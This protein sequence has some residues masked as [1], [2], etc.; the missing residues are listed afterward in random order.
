MERKEPLFHDETG[1]FMSAT[2]V[3]AR[4]PHILVADDDRGICRL[5]QEFL[6]S[7][8]ARITTVG[9]GIEAIKV[10]LDDPADLVITDYHMPRLD[11]VEVLRSV[12]GHPSRRPIPVLMV[13]ALHQSL[14]RELEV[15]RLAPDA[16]F[17]KPFDGAAVQAKARSLL[18]RS[19]S[20]RAAAARTP[21]VTQDDELPAP[22]FAGFRVLDMIG[23]GGMATVYKALQVSVD[24]V[25][26]LKVL[27]P[28]LLKHKD[29]R[30]RFHREAK[31]LAT[32]SH[33]N[34]VQLIDF[35]SS[36]HFDFLVMEYVEG[37]SLY[38]VMASSWPEPSFYESLVRQVEAALMY[39]HGQGVLHRDLKPTNILMDRNRHVRLSDFGIALH[40]GVPYEWEEEAKLLLGTP[41]FLPPE[42]RGKPIGDP[43]P[44]VDVYALGVTFYQMFTRYLPDEKWTN[45]S[46][47]N[48]LVSSEVDRLVLRAIDPNPARRP[49]TIPDLCGPL[50]EALGRLSA[51]HACAESDSPSPAW[52]K[53]GSGGSSF[54]RGGAL[55]GRGGASAKP[56]FESKKSAENR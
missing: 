45:P 14:R 3:D 47:V 6:R 9:D 56:A 20:R 33:P 26:A 11:G 16:Y 24:R 49:K 43:N 5:L 17:D 27:S 1:R 39:L 22:E 34:I 46:R 31:I 42:L 23:S 21:T 52:P 28:K 15:L 50:A 35:K 30:D 40:M 53:S 19:L 37:P 48:P 41:Q 13:S 36:E 8:D 55:G 54:F 2:E 10:L 18:Q 25:V 51:S 12:K 38:D 44:E 32:L 7:L 4:T 29:Q